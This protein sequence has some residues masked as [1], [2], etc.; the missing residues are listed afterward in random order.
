MHSGPALWK[1]DFSPL[2]LHGVLCCGE[3]GNPLEATLSPRG[4]KD[5]DNGIGSGGGGGGSGRRAE[6][7]LFG[8]GG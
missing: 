4:G 6:S 1:V 7:F 3:A 2:L 8:R 5:A